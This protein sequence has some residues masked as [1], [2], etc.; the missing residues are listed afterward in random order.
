MHAAFHLCH[1]HYRPPLF[2]TSK[3]VFIAGI[4][5]YVRGGVRLTELATQS[6]CVSLVFYLSF[7]LCVASTRQPLGFLLWPCGEFF[8]LITHF[9]VCGVKHQAE[10]R[11]ALLLTL[12]TR[13]LNHL[14]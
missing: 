13:Q 1:H 6:L 3:C 10:W 9:F 11:K 7:S 4:C 14:W 12:L 5:V 8:S 2:S